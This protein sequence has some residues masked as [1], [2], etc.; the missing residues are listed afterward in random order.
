MEKTKKRKYPVRSGLILLFA[1]LLIGLF[2]L[3]VSGATSGDGGTT[4]NEFTWDWST[5]NVKEGA[6]AN[7]SGSLSG[8]TLTLNITAKPSKYIPGDNGCNGIGATPAVNAETTVNTVNVKNNTNSTI[9]ISSITMEKA[10]CKLSQ[11]SKLSHGESFIVAVTAEPKDNMDENPIAVTGKIIIV[12]TEIENVDL[13]FYGADGA[14]YSY[15]D[16]LLDSASDYKTEPIAVGS[17][18]TLPVAPT[19]SSGTF[20]GWRMSHDGSLRSA[21]ESVTVNNDTSVYPVIKPDGMVTPFTVGGTPYTYWTDAAKAA[22]NGGTIILNQ[23]YTLPTSMVGNGV[24]PAGSPYIS[25]INGK[26]NY[27]IPNGVIFQIP[28]DLA[29]TLVTNGDAV[30]DAYNAEVVARSEYRALTLESGTKITI[31]NGGA[32]SV[33]S[34]RANQFIG[35]IGPYGAIYMNEGSNITVQSGGTLYAWGYLFHGT[36]GSGTVTVESGGTVYEPMSTMDYPG[37]SS[38]TTTIK[39]AG[40][41]PMRS[42]SVRNVEVPM[43]LK[44]GAREYVFS[45]LFGNN[46]LV[47]TNPLYVLMIANGAVSGQT[48]V[49]QNAGTITKSFVDGRMHIVTDGDFTLNT[50]TVEV[51]KSMGTYKIS[52]SETSGFYLPSC[53]DWIHASGTL[54]IKDNIIICEGCTFTI[55][56]GATVD[57]NGKNIYILD[58]DD[59]PGAVVTSNGCSIDVQ[60]VHGKYYT[61][62]PKDAV[63]DVNGTII[64]SGGF[65]T[66][67]NGACITSSKGT[68][69]IQVS[70]TSGS[71]TVAVK[72]TNSYTSVEIKPAVLQHA[73]GSDP[74]STATAGTYNHSAD[75]GRWVNGDHAVGERIEPT[76]TENGS[77]KTDCPC[78]Y[79]V[80]KTISALGHEYKAITIIEPTCTEQGCTNYQCNRCSDTYQDDW[81][82]A[83]G[84]SI[85]TPTVVLPTC[86]SAGYEKGT[87]EVCGAD[88]ETTLPID[89]T[90]HTA[91]HAAE[92]FDSHLSINFSYCTGC[93]HSFNHSAVVSGYKDMKT[94]M[95]SAY[96]YLDQAL[97]VRFEI[98]HAAL[99]TWLDG[100]GYSKVYLQVTKATKEW[101]MDDRC[102]ISLIDTG[103]TSGKTECEF[104]QITALEMTDGLLYTI[105]AFDAENNVVRYTPIKEFTIESYANTVFG[106]NIVSE[107]MKTLIATL[108]E[109]GKQSQIYKHHYN[110]DAYVPQVDEQY[111]GYVSTRYDTPNDVTASEDTENPSGRIISA[112]LR[113]NE[114]VVPQFR[115]SGE[116]LTPVIEVNGQKV[117]T[118]LYSDAAGNQYVYVDPKYMSPAMM[119]QAVTVWLV[120]ESSNVVSNTV[121]YSVASYVSRQ[122]N[123]D[124]VNENLVTYLACLMAY[125]DAF[126]AASK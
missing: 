15:G 92:Q 75:H 30:L 117:D 22:A 66:S 81:L 111:Q 52:S 85:E 18:I 50:L 74:L 12:Y 20:A 40:V 3:L 61:N 21:A 29:N 37:S 43:T 58:A 5:N 64:A 1:W 112:M 116:G 27:I 109:F 11:G 113:I 67:K 115:Y 36:D 63:V 89:P 33:S 65:Y 62:V 96:V 48:P 83:V 44:S 120:D 100:S 10:E 103:K 105:V 108:L 59:D 7:V 57:A 19:I 78:G 4:N 88:V 47:G 6:E 26:V 80:E 119:R 107:E 104:P 70:G 97:T 86:T 72:N 13:T 95:L 49:L 124:P 24:S 118:V 121:T 73:D 110:T 98:D 28:Y 93:N 106:M 34:G 25:E 69:Q 41:F 71:T 102:L 35:Q 51:S 45:C 79:H 56:E 99:L 55:N 101:E 82:P 123:K 46:V 68:G 53:W 114:T 38:A 17:S 2:L 122:M 84:H 54:M 91:T 125:G 87:C 14:S 31:A 90:N 16:A 42:Y 39:D 8:N 60:N 32:I 126:T 76:C 94:G 77:E 23:N 9:S